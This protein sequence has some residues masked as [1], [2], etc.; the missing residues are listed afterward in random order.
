MCFICVYKNEILPVETFSD[1]N[2]KKKCFLKYY[3]INT[4]TKEVNFE[5]E[6]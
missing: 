4:M 1:M 6:L 2:V 3:Y 5:V